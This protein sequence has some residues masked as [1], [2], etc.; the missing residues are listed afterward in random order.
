MSTTATP[1][2]TRTKWTV[3]PSHSELTFKVKHL[4]IANV[5][6]AFQ[7]FDAGIEAT[8]TDFANARVQATIAAASI[9]T[10]DE[11]R[12]KHLRSAD[13]FDAEKFPQL[14]FTGTTME[15]VGGNDYKLTGDL[16]IKNTTKPVTLDVEFGGKNTDPWGNEKLAFALSGKIDRKEWGLNWNSALETGGV[17]VSDEVRIS[18]ELQFV[19]QA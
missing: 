18:A 3:D 13:F 6:G 7:K 5:K 2:A 15:H 14:T 12:D 19:K 9:F 4:M 16:T 10:N 1:T 11:G 8:G 17:L